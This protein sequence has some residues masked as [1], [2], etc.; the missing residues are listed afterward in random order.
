MEKL[1][2][3]KN[4][5]SEISGLSADNISLETKFID[6]PDWDSL[7]AIS[8]LAYCESVFGVS[9]PMSIMSK[10]QTVGEI[11]DAIR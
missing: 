7:K 1:E 4:I 11:I 2:M 9:L 10:A 8:F 6:L 5:L 3:I